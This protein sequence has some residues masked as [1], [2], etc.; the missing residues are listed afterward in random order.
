MK[1]IKIQP[2]GYL[3][4]RLKMTTED[5]KKVENAL[6]SPY[7]KVNMKI[8][9]YDVTIICVLEKPLHYCLGVYIDEKIKGEWI[10]EDCEIR[11]R[12]YQKH[13]K[14]L[15]DS[16]QK[17]RLKRE[18]KALREEILK[19]SSYDWYEP[20][21]KSVRSMKS[22]FIKNNNSIELVEAI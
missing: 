2:A 13:T 10:T 3:E 14:S 6:L 21:W 17:K 5:W 8:D 1:K 19:Q 20:Y 11:R 12:F 16:K 22:H 7:G 18:R 15:L 9:G 4:R